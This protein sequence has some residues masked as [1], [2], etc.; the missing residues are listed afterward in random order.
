MGAYVSVCLTLLQ[1]GAMF[2]H[3]QCIFM[4]VRK[5]TVCVFREGP[6]GFVLVLGVSD[7]RSSTGSY[8]AKHWTHSH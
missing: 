1:S 8:E 4:C 7:Q 5:G 3:A 2:T 6:F